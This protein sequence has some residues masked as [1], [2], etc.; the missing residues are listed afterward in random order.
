MVFIINVKG[1]NTANGSAA[2]QLVKFKMMIACI[3]LLSNVV[4]KGKILLNCYLENIHIHWLKAEGA[5]VT[6][7]DKSDISKIRTNSNF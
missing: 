4:L 3:S 1:K 2:H 7:F 5:P 6:I